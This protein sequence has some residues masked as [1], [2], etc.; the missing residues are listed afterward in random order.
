MPE[1]KTEF[2]AVVGDIL[3]ELYERPDL[4]FSSHTLTQKLNPNL[5]T[6]D[7]EYRTA[8]AHVNSAIETHL[9]SGLLQGKRSRHDDGVFFKDLKLT[10]KGEKAAI[11]ERDQR[12]LPG[13]VKK[14]M[15]I[16]DLVR[17]RDR[18]PDS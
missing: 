8:F 17:E 7:P 3:I 10:R 12:E 18:H 14:L 13:K 15:D 2:A 9:G 4:T 16:V 6:S 5:A 1:P 11:Q